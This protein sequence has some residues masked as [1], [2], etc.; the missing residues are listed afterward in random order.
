[1]TRVS[2]IFGFFWNSNPN[3]RSR[4]VWSEKKLTTIVQNIFPSPF[5]LIWFDD[6]NVFFS[7]QTRLAYYLFVVYT[8]YK[9]WRHV[10]FVNRRGMYTLWL[11]RLLA[12]FGIVSRNAI[13]DKGILF[14]KHLVA[15]VVGAEC[16]LLPSKNNN[17]NRKF[18]KFD[19]SLL[20]YYSKEEKK[21]AS[22]RSYEQF[23]LQLRSWFL[24]DEKRTSVKNHILFCIMYIWDWAESCKKWIIAAKS[25]LW[26]SVQV[27]VISHFPQL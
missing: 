18:D 5:R 6:A 2:T 19:L 11:C 8:Y 17:H 26:N 14:T 1:M 20:F 24:N 9:F 22:S 25:E 16:E 27:K 15:V 13:F 3:F 10:K 21:N 12:G 4:P 7:D 23:F